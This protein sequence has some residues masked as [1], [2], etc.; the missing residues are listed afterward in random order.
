MDTV[1]SLIEQYRQ[2]DTELEKTDQSHKDEIIIE[3]ES[4]D[5]PRVLPFL[6]EVLADENEYDLARIEVLKILELREHRD[7]SEDE[8]IA[9][10]VRRVMISDPDDDVRNYAAIAAGNYVTADG[11]IKELEKLILNNN[12]DMNLRS[13][14]F[15]AIKRMGP[16]DEGM[17]IMKE[18]V[19]TSEFGTPASMI[20]SHWG[21]SSGTD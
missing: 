5:D 19:K 12:E 20:L 16:T 1:A 4:S 6:L 14:A 11:M 21:I 13:N 17:R 3:L 2:E 18:L 8:R 9:E 10:L 7:K 15:A